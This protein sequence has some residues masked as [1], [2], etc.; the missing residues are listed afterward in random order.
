M[1]KRMIAVVLAM[2]MVMTSG[3]SERRYCDR[4]VLWKRRHGHGRAKP[5]RGAVLRSRSIFRWTVTDK[6]ICF[7]QRPPSMN[8]LLNI[9]AKYCFLRANDIY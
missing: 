3:L 4:F 7:I 8:L 2:V 1:K 5:G 9:R 6:I